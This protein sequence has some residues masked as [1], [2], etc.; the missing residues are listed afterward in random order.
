MATDEE[1]R[2][3][4][5]VEA[6]SLVFQCEYCGFRSDDDRDFE[7]NGELLCQVCN[8]EYKENCDGESTR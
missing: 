7:L 5:A 4:A 8:D 3:D 1:R 6:R 2:W